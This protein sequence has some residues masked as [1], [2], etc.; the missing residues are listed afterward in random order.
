MLEVAT[1]QMFADLS[2]LDTIALVVSA[3]HQDEGAGSSVLP[4]V[5]EAVVGVLEE[6]A[7][8]TE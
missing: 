5:L 3:L 1:E 6:S 4:S 7:A 2:I 8:G